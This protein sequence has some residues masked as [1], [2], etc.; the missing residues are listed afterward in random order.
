MNIRPI[1]FLILLSLSLGLTAQ[2]K[3]KVQFNYGIKAGFQA[4]T[5]NDPEFE[6]DG[7][8]FDTDNIQSNRIG[9]AISPFVRLTKNKF[10]IQTEAT[11]GITNH[12]FDFHDEVEPGMEDIVPNKTVYDL[13]TYCIQVPILF[14]YN[15]IEYDKYS[16][17]LFTGPRTKFI[18]N[19]LTEQDFKHFKYENL[20]E[21][22]SSKAYF[23]EAGLSIKMSRVF[24]DI[25]YDVG[26]NVSTSHILSHDDGKTFKSERRDNVLSFSVGF[27]F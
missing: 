26:L 7:Y 25:T 5:Y 12:S 14:G 20:E 18:L 13:R 10:F 1:I 24:I 15:I 27:L 16:M 8:V 9:Y 17:S 4:V 21:I 11:F 3:R 22:L 23:W 6:I 19:S 2:E